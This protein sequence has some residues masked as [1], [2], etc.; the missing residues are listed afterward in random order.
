AYTFNTSG[1][2]PI[3][4]FSIDTKLDDGKPN[5]GAIIARGITAVNAVPTASATSTP[6]VCTIG[7]GTATDTYNGVIASG[8]NDLSCGMRLRFQ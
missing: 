8:G 2:T 5:T 4:A 6:A 1:M 7:S 3:S